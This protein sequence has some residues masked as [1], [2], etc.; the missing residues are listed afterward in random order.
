MKNDNEIIYPFYMVKWCE[1]EKK[2]EKHFNTFDE[3][4]FEVYSLEE[5]KLIWSCEV[6]SD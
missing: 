4:M 5:K 6:I 3:A 1:N 2:H